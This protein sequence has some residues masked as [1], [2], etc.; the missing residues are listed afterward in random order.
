MDKQIISALITVAGTLFGVWLGSL[1][2]RRASREAIAATHQNAIELIHI[3]S[4][5][6]AGLRLREAFAPELA[7][8]QHPEG[9]GIAEFSHILEVAFEKHQ[10][11]VNEFRFFLAG[12]ELDSFNKAWREYYSYP[13]EDKPNFSKHMMLS[14]EDIQK[15][16][17]EIKTILKF[18]KDK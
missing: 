2:S 13:Y 12:D 9:R 3:N 1:I 14:E 18:T 5:K 15:T 10:M 4:K 11:A 6:I 17:N 16:I 7:K 8:L